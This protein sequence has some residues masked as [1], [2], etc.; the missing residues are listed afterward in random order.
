[1]VAA[2][3]D[4]EIDERNLLGEKDFGSVQFFWSILE[5]YVTFIKGAAK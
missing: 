2:S 5:F 1:M 3:E 4:I